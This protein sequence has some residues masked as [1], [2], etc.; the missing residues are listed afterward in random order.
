MQKAYKNEELEAQIEKQ[1][2]EERKLALE[3]YEQALQGNI[4]DF[5]EVFDR[6]ENKY[7]NED[8]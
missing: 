5:D 7:K 6:L 8:V 4:K 2:L 3:G 1:K